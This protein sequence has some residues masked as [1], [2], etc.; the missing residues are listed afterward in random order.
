MTIG[1]ALKQQRLHAGLTQKEMTAG[2]VS[3][4]FYSKVERDVH[5]I[6]ANLL[7]DIL[8]AHHFD[9]V[10]FFSRINNQPSKVSPDFE[11]ITQIVFA[12]NRKDLEAL[13]KIAQ[14]LEDGKIEAS[15]PWLKLRL[16]WAYAW[17]LNSNKMV[18]SANQNRVKKLLSEGNWDRTAYHYLSQAVVLLEIDDAYQLV[19]EAFKSYE[20]KP[21][22]DT[23][24]L[25]FIALVAVN[26]LNCCYHQQAKMEYIQR[27]LNFLQ[28]MPVDPAIG[29]EKIVGKYYEALFSQDEKSQK[30]IIAVLKMSNYYS[31]IADTIEE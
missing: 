24:T 19:N 23:F 17:I 28:K 7:I 16:E 5:A 21:Q 30:L 22:N 27:A 9:V 15:T 26:F 31:V 18:S 1:Q 14:D 20:K 3:E 8:S 12:Q 11:I 6:D 10:G 13:D 29:L 2:L 4:S 25:Q